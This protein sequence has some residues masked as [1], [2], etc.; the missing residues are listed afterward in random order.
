MAFDAF[1]KLVRGLARTREGIAAS[2]RTAFSSH[3]VDEA[4]LEDLETSLLSAD[5]GPALTQEIV[6]GVRRQARAGTL[7]GSGLRAALRAA[8]HAALAGDG[9]APA[10]V[11]PPRV[12][13]IVGVNGGGKTTTIGKLAARERASGRKVIVVAADTFRAAAIDQL[14]RWAER[15][16]VEVIRH[17][18]GSDPSA[19]VFDALTAAR[20]RGID[21]VLVD[22]AGRLH[23]KV[24]LMAELQKMARIA[25]REV[26]G[27]PH[28]VLLVV[29]ATTGQNGLQQAREFTKAAVITGVVLTKLDGTAKGG[30]AL[31]IRRE[32][33]VP[34]RYV[35]V[36]EALEDL[37][38]F[39]TA[40]YVDGLLGGED[41][42]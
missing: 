40:A 38:E 16:G 15:A 33:G 22:T 17:R 13:F 34:I 29:D 25:A 32:L 6:E 8:L 26:P 10:P 28:E 35:G 2:L 23:T 20:A 30:V 19:V 41:A 42:A 3:V 21:T 9:T 39:D 31:V 37:L 12:V 7:D 36:G 1:K 18:E 24:P 5:I 4:T 14:E 11:A 27:A